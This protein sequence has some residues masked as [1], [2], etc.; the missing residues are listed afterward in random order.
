MNIT[1]LIG[2]G[3]DRNLGLATSYRDFVKEY[4]NTPGSTKNL[5]K[6]REYINE[7]E[8]LWSQ[9]EIEIGADGNAADHNPVFRNAVGDK[10][11]NQSCMGN[12]IPEVMTG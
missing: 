9:A 6:F 3:F 8:D 1:F 7:N 4:K 10:F 2:N 11:R 12:E 5:E